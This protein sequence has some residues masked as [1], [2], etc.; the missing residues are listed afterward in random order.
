MFHLR[1]DKAVAKTMNAGIEFVKDDKVAVTGMVLHQNGH[2][3]KGVGK[4]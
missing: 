3:M 1:D 2:D 4:R